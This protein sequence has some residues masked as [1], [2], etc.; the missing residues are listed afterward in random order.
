[1]IQMFLMYLLAINVITLV[2]SIV[3][4]GFA[5]Y[6]RRRVPEGLM[7]TMSFIG[8]APGALTARVLTGHKRL[9]VDYCASLTLIVL[10]QAGIVAAIWSQT[11]RAE[12]FSLYER[13]ASTFEGGGAEE[14]QDITHVSRDRGMPRRFGPG[15]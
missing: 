11:V 9:K 5:V 13:F 14:A 7:L 12:T 8:G 1:M 15:S 2:V 6:K 3:D 4:K 10:L